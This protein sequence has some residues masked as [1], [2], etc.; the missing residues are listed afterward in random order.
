[1][2]LS[3]FV[4]RRTS[5]FSRF[6][7]LLWILKI[8]FLNSTRNHF[9][10]CV[11]GTLKCIHPD[12]F[13]LNCRLGCFLGEGI[14]PVI[15]L[16]G[17]FLKCKSVGKRRPREEETNRHICEKLCVRKNETNLS[18]ASNSKVNL[19][20]SG[21]HLTTFSC[22]HGINRNIFDPSGNLSFN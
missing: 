2:T 5:G 12:L 15:A 17:F 6:F 21:N 19:C 10:F 20:V 16:P 14:K 18:R 8:S 9:E 22:K 1:M 4:A 7:V 13:N 3:H 11:Y